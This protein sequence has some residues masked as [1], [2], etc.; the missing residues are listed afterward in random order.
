MHSV[1]YAS[2][3]LTFPPIDKQTFPKEQN[4]EVFVAERIIFGPWAVQ[5]IGRAIAKQ[6]RHN[7]MQQPVL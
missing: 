7:Y 6:V 5:K 2:Y 3:V 1:Y 4:H